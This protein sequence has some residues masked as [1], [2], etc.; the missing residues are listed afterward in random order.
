M[1]KKEVKSNKEKKQ[2]HFF[3]DFKAEIKKVIWPT[4]KQ[5]V[6]ST[7]AIIVMVLIVAFIVFVLDLV[8]DAF[9]QYALTNLQEIVQTEANG[10][11]SEEST[12]ETTTD[13]TT[14]EESTDETTTDETTS[15]ESSSDEET[16]EESTESTT[17]TNEA[18][19]E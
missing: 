8:F 12:D 4:P 9:N 13:E 3:K 1:A 19:S 14:S 16:S 7:I 2:K 18:S 6:N 15:D 11:T 5:L 10:T 17:E